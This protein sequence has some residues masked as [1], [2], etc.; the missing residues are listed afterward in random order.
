MSFMARRHLITFIQGFG[1]K[2]IFTGVA[3]DRLW[4]WARNVGLLVARLHAKGI[5]WREVYATDLAGL[6]LETDLII[7]RDWRY[8]LEAVQAFRD[9]HANIPVIAMVF[10]GPR[11]CLEWQEYGEMKALFGEVPPLPGTGLAPCDAA[12]F[13]ADRVVIRSQ[14]IAELFA[15]MGADAANGRVARMP[16]APMW[17]HDDGDIVPAKLP[18]LR[19]PRHK[20][21][22]DILFI[23]D[24]VIRK[25]LFRLYAAFRMLSIP[26]KRLHVL[27]GLLGRCAGG[28]TVAVSPLVR[29]ALGQMASDPDVVVHAPYCDLKGFAQTHRGIDLLVCPSL[30]D[31]GPN[32]LVEACQLGIPVLASTMCGAAADLPR[33]AVVPVVAPRWWSASEHPEAFT[34]RLAEAITR[35]YEARHPYSSACAYDSAAVLREISGAWDSILAPHLMCPGERVS[36]IGGNS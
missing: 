4:G 11:H 13:V 28:E 2:D 9:R 14:L 19:R 7:L 17:S 33:N 34:F 5:S 31:H 18:V 22:F 25:G 10:H 26:G 16:H 29:A 27:N 24:S 35:F 6:K 36:S 20:K 21:T 8:S 15:E 1:R 30:I 12:L 23:G 3:P 32:T